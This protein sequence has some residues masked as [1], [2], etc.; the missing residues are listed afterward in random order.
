MDDL[1]SL[2]QVSNKKIVILTC[3]KEITIE[4]AGEPYAE[5]IKHQNN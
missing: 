5:Q 4:L 3:K 1:V 2:E